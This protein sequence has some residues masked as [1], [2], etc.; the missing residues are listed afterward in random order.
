MRAPD[1][2]VDQTIWDDGDRLWRWTIEQLYASDLAEV[3][4][5]YPVS[6]PDRHSP[7][8]W[9][10]ESREIDARVRDELVRCQRED[11]APCP[12]SSAPHSCSG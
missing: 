9:L 5:I 10:L 12:S 1:S 11:A 3:P 6:H 4:W 2:K 7:H 8:R